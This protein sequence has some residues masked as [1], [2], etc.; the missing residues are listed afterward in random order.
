MNLNLEDVHGDML[1]AI[2][3]RYQKTE[4]FPAYD[5]TRAFALAVLS[6]DDDISIAEAHLDVDTLTG[7]EL[8]EYI[9]QHRG[10]SRKYATY[11]EAILRVVTG[12]G[13]VQ[14][15][16]LFSTLSGVE[17]YAISDGTYA[18]GDTFTVRAY[19]AGDSGNVGPGTITYMP[20]T[21]AGIGAVTNDEAASGGYD[22][23]SDEEFR[24][25]YYNDLQNP[26]NGSNK[27]AYIQWALSVAGVG[28]V[29]IFPQALGANTVEVCIVDANMEPAGTSLIQQVQALIDPN[30]NGD[31]SGQ[32]P[33]GAAATATTA[34]A[35]QISVSA[36]VTLA[37]GYT[38]AGVTETVQSNLTAYLREIAFE[39]G[40][41][42]VSYTQIASRIN[43]TEGVLD[44]GSLKVNDGI[45]NVALEDRQT[46]VLGS[47]I[48]T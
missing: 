18:Q 11:S 27:Q 32:A 46:P 10:L 41:T 21:I 3:D 38:L 14:A 26:N 37:E 35:L 17:F 15:G 23:E 16:D 28:R 22:A 33:L 19:V 47:V 31:G 40:T 24:D 13:T 34:T 1:L 12:S 39:E 2:P 7:V 44:H 8:D 42:Y 5:F 48:L 30:G 25:R 9:K 6:L 29:K 4:G 36:T 20:V 43:A 45:T